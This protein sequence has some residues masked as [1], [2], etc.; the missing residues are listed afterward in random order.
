MSQFYYMIIATL[1]ITQASLILRSLI[2]IIMPCL[3][4]KYLEL[5]NANPIVQLVLLV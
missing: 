2:A 3:N 1:G 4:P 5:F